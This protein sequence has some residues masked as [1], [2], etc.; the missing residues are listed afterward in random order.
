MKNRH[1]VVWTQGMFLTPQHFQT[2]EQFLEN[3]VDFRFRAS[4]YANWGVT[5]LTIDSDALANHQFRVV[6][7]HAVM[8]DGEPVEIPAVDAAPDSRSFAQIFTANRDS[9]DVFLAIP[10]NS[11][12]ARNVTI[13]DPAQKKAAPTTRYV[14]ET[15]MLKDE[16]LGD[17]EK[18]VDLAR[19]TF[20]LIFGDEY[21]D[22]MASFRIAQI[23]RDAGGRP[24]LNPKFAAPCLDLA[25]SRYL[26]NL[27]QRQI[28]ILVTKSTSLAAQ[29][30]HRSKVVADFGP[31][32]ITNFLILHTVNSFLP[33]LRHIWKV[34]QGHPELAYRTLLRLAGALSTFS[35]A[36]TPED[37][38]DYDHDDLGRCFTLLDARIQELMGYFVKQKF[39]VIPLSL[40]DRFFWT[41]A[42]TE[43]SH[44]QNTQFYLSVSAR[45]GVDDLI[46]KLPALAKISAQPDIQRIVNNSL[47]GLSLRHAPA[48]QASIPVRLEHQYFLINQGGPLWEALR[49]SRQIAVY[50]PG[51]IIEPKME[52]FVALE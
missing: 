8:P 5:K 20:R 22:G 4:H 21:K 27:L 24:I 49:K 28:E 25:S 35:D 50:T 51:E 30:I 18:P 2:Q 47:P 36:G 44:F 11:P 9:L 42:V 38:P 34:R 45:M 46:R 23:V 16:N 17:D 37:L 6:D 26:L 14:A 12:G 29:R 48:P 33:E 13:P 43:D 10:E 41:G 40:S 7:C 31:G 3:A 39:A 15:C 52:I 19:R 32:G 1:R